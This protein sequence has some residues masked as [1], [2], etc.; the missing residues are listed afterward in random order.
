[1]TLSRLKKKKHLIIGI[2][3]TIYL[4]LQNEMKYRF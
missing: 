2:L 3:T 1:M 4:L